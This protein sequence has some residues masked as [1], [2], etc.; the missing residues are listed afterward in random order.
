MSKRSQSLL[1]LLLAKRRKQG[2][3]QFTHG[4]GR[5]DLLQV[6]PAI[7]MQQYKILLCAVQRHESTCNTSRKRVTARFFFI[8]FTARF[9]SRKSLTSK[10]YDKIHADSN[11]AP[12]DYYGKLYTVIQQSAIN[13]NAS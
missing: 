10:N 11:D 4:D 2:L 5:R 3:K 6:R 7:I 9:E 13:R 1:V 8:C 12:I